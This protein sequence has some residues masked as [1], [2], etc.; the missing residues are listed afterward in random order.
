MAAKKDGVLK[1]SHFL[2]FSY[3]HTKKK[4]I[5]LLLFPDLTRPSTMFAQL[6]PRLGII[7]RLKGEGHSKA[8]STNSHVFLVWLF[9]IFC[10]LLKLQW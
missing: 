3:V 6:V 9:L 2:L 10:F 7:L 4:K 5:L 1:K 8:M